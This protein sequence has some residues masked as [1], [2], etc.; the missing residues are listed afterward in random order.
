MLAL[1][2][3][4]C[5]ATG[6]PRADGQPRPAHEALWIA[7]EAGMLRAYDGRSDRPMATVDIGQAPLEWNLVGGGGVIWAYAN[8]GRIV[9]IDA[10]SARVTARLRLPVIDKPGISSVYYTH[11]TLW[12]QRR[13]GLWHVGDSGSP[14]MAAVPAD[15]TAAFVATD[16]RWLWASSTDGRLLR[17]DPVDGSTTA[18]GQN[19]VLK[20]AAAFA[21]GPDG[22]VVASPPTVAILNPGTAETTNSISLPDDNTGVSLHVAAS[23]AWAVTGTAAV[24]LRYPATGPVSLSDS[25]WTAPPTTGFGS[26][27]IGD[28]LNLR[29]IRIPLA[30]DAMTERIAL[31]YPENF[32][33]ADLV[34]NVFAGSEAIWI[35]DYDGPTGIMRLQ[36]QDNRVTRVVKPN[37]ELTTAAIVAEQPG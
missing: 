6:R 24:P 35:V 34:L 28:D 30:G 7:D 33:G 19:P 15:F 5:T 27:W 25:A 32:E 10:K 23:Y 9:R 12:I 18:I 20:G 26:L 8:D 31:R 21:A 37:V 16:E 13:D 11:A 22:L 14:T 2:V 4:G 3:T 36:P 1:A 29:L 17:L